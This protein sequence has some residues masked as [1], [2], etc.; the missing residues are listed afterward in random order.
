MTPI[1]VVCIRKLGYPVPLFTGIAGKLK[2]KTEDG[3]RVKID[4]VSYYGEIPARVSEESKSDEE[5]FE[6]E[7]SEPRPSDDEMFDIGTEA[8]ANT[9]INAETHLPHRLGQAP[10]QPAADDA[11][12]THQDDHRGES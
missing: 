3:K 10:T 7:S 11:P 4:G 9:K 5:D 12:Q 1:L 8:Q 6:E 2:T